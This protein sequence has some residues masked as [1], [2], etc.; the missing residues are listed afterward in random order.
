MIE[1]KIV[2]FI[3]LMTLKTTSLSSCSQ[4]KNGYKKYAPG[5]EILAKMSKKKRCMFSKPIAMKQ[6]QCMTE[7]NT[8][9]Q[10][11]FFPANP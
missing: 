3:G 8:L 2:P 5:P 1:N 9:V 10:A 7:S 6:R 11:G 4:P